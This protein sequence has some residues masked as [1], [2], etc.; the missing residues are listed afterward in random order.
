MPPSGD[1]REGED[2]DAGSPGWLRS[3][4]VERVAFDDEDSEI[5]SVRWEGFVR[6][7]VSETH[8][9][10]L[11]LAKDADAARLRVGDSWVLERGWDESFDTG[12]SSSSSS[13]SDSSNLHSSAAAVVR[14][15]VDLVAGGLYFVRLEWLRRSIRAEDDVD[16]APISL[17]WSTESRSDATPITRTDF[18]ADISDI[19]GSPFDVTVD[20]GA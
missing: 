13:S 4:V 1:V 7:S 8:T 9:F 17:S 12:R 15:D 2:G 3:E 6:A 14:G 20:Y 18:F 10:H 5:E 19:S 16:G 11:H